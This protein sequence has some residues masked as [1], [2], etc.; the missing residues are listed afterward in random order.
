MVS[1]LPS[2]QLSR[3][4]LQSGLLQKG[5]NHMQMGLPKQ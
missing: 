1:D 2:V 4:I 5:A 3:K